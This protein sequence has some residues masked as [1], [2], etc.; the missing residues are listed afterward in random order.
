MFLKAIETYEVRMKRKPKQPAKVVGVVEATLKGKKCKAIKMS[1]GT[2]VFDKNKDVEDILYNAYSEKFQTGTVT[3]KSWL[4][5]FV[6]KSLDKMVSSLQY[7][8]S[9]SFKALESVNKISKATN[10]YMGKRKAIDSD[11][12]EYQLYKMLLP[13]QKEVASDLSKNKLLICARRTGKTYYEAVA[14]IKHCL[15]GTDDILI[16]DRL[17]RKKRCAIY[18]ALTIQKAASNIWKTLN[19]IIESAHIPVDKIDNG[20]YRI[21]FGNGAFIQL[22]GNNDKIEREKMRGDDWSMAIIDEVQSQSSMYYIMDSL[23]KPIVKARKGEFILSGTGPLIRGFWS[24]L[25]EN[26]KDKG[27]SIYHKTVYDNLTIEDPDKYIEEAL[28]DFGGDRNN[29]TFQRE[30]LGNICWDDNLLIYPKTTYYKELPADFHPVYAFAGMDLGMRDDTSIEWILIDDFGKGYVVSEWSQNNVDATTIFEKATTTREFIIK[31]YG[32]SEDN[33]HIVCDTNEQN[34]T[35]DFYNRGL[36]CLENAIKLPLKYSYALINEAMA[37]GKLMIPQDGPAATDCA[38]TCYK[39]DQENK[40]VV[41]EED[42]KTH[43]ENAMAAIR[44]A[45]TSYCVNILHMSAGITEQPN[46]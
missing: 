38:Y 45:W 11:F 17:V 46:D 44:Y 34:M 28:R 16:G 6:D 36:Y 35:A 27:W 8:S 26:G 22:S 19:D 21:E 14:L 1:D 23:L 18:I 5:Y 10:T 24:D 25:I 30:Y 39:F 41:Y 40:K 20:K 43:H 13:W 33:V 42:K 37:N 4:D 15:K 29:P 9:N 32:I 31:N 3:G 2:L 7:D 12:M